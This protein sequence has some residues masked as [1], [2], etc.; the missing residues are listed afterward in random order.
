VSA[1]DAGVAKSV[2]AQSQALHPNLVL[3]TTILASSRAGSNWLRNFMP[4]RSP[5]V[6]ALAASTSAFAFVRNPR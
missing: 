5:A 6:T 1:F 2:S 3:A 4:P